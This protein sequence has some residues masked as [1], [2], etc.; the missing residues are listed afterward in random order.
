VLEQIFWEDIRPKVKTIDPKLTSLIDN[1]SPDKKYPLVSGKY[2]YGQSIVKDGQFIKLDNNSEQNKLLGQLTYSQIPLFYVLHN[3]CEVYIDTDYRIIPLNLFTPSS[4]L[5]LF[6]TMDVLYGRSS[7]PKWSVSAGARSIFML[8]KIYGSAG[9]RRLRTRYHIPLDTQL[10]ELSDH[11]KIF[12]IIA[13]HKSF[14]QSWHTEIL[15]FTGAWFKNFKKGDIH[16]NNFYQYLMRHA[17]SQAQFAIEKVTLRLYWEHFIDIISSRNFKPIPYIS[18]QIKHIMLIATGQWPGFT[19]GD[20]EQL[21]APMTGLQNA[22]IDTYQL[23]KYLPTIMYPSL[24]DGKS[25]VY[26]SLAYPTLLEGSPHRKSKS[27]IM[28]DVKEI[29]LLLDIL[30]SDKT[31]NIKFKN[32]FLDNIALD[33]FHV[34]NDPLGEVKS[35]ETLISTD[36]NLLADNKNYP[37]RIFCPTSSFWRGCIQLSAKS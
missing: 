1:I 11:W 15:L 9:F 37:S 26:Y 31:K 7:N 8:P 23:K 32:N 19:T 35:S 14:E 20:S 13:N 28:L 16:W 21:F 4:I 33:Y 3:S 22:F 24:F 36:P 18:D 29:K 25:P 17:W 2:S 34:E 12:K 5:G 10:K 30:K 27:T 6:E